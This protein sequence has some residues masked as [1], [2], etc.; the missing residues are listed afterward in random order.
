[1]AIAA[2]VILPDGRRRFRVVAGRAMRIVS[3]LRSATG[4]RTRVLAGE[5]RILWPQTHSDRLTG[6]GQE[7]PVLRPEESRPLSVSTHDGVH[8]DVEST[9]SVGFN[10]TMRSVLSRLR[11]MARRPRGCDTAPET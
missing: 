8:A 10:C 9:H 3:R 5:Y 7:L 1:M 2:A 4:H 6:R 11:P